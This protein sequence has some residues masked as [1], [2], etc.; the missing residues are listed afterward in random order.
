MK[1]A[2]SAQTARCYEELAR[3]LLAIAE[4]ALGKPW[5]ADTQAAIEVHGARRAQLARATWRQYRAALSWFF[6]HEGLAEAAVY[7]RSLRQ[8]PCLRRTQRTSAQ[9]SKY[10]PLERLTRLIEELAGARGRYDRATGLWLLA[11]Y[12]LG[13]R[14]EEW[15]AA[16]WVGERRLRVRNAKASQHRT[17]GAYRTLMLDALA[18]EEMR[19][20]HEF[21]AIVAAHPNW[22]RLYTACRKRLHKLNRRLWP[23]AR[24][25][26]TLYSG[27]HQFASDH[28]ASHLSRDE[29][30]ALMGHGSTLT[31]DR[32]Y[33]RRGYG[34]RR[35]RVRPSPEDVERVRARNRSRRPA[36][37]F[38]NRPPR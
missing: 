20:V 38:Q 25:H 11:N 31:S 18:A 26:I 19:V 33:G 29:V 24:R 12:Y 5:R 35:G 30:A 37:E 13:L 9:K 28:K 36:P 4:R 17:F 8:S 1:P 10:L 34:R 15:W 7:A 16:Q 32:H 6:E 3:R 21:M 23:R 14:P 27:R 22:R 2:V